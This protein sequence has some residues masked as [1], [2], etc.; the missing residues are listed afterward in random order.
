MFN[1]ERIYVRKDKKDQSESLNVSFSSNNSFY[2]NLPIEIKRDIISLI[3]AGY[4]RKIIIKLYILTNP[5]NI[6]EAIHFLTKENGIYQHIFF[7]SQNKEDS[8]EICGEKK[9]IHNNEMNKTINISFY[10]MDSSERSE[11][12]NKIN[13][14]N[15]GEKNYICKIC[16][17]EIINKKE[18]NNNKCEQCE[19]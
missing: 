1:T 14:K 13:I 3:K 8:C 17:E 6:S 9:I 11:K 5:S 19:T 15:E 18:I 16:E 7:D 4:D 2:E 12:I 10:K